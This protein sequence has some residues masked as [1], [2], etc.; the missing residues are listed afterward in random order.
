MIESPE[1]DCFITE[2]S[3]GSYIVFRKG[4]VDETHY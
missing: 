4:I 2:G 1:T 3:F